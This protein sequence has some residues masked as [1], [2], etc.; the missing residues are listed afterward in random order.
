MLPTQS[1]ETKKG[2]VEELLLVRQQ[3][4]ELARG[5][6]E[7]KLEIA[8]EKAKAVSLQTQLDA[9][10]LPWWEDVLRSTVMDV[11]YVVFGVWLGVKAAES[12]S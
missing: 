5:V 4:I 3:N 12:A 2:P 7:L 8:T 11:V 9:M 6:S 10:D 1:S